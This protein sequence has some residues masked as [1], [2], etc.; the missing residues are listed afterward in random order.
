MLVANVF[1]CPVDALDNQA[2]SM[3]G[4]EWDIPLDHRAWWLYLYSWFVVKDGSGMSRGTQESL[5]FRGNH[6]VQAGRLVTQ[7]PKPVDGYLRM[8]PER[9]LVVFEEPTCERSVRF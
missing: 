6:L 9:L 2:G 3:Q 8:V 7:P 1:R 4:K 5:K